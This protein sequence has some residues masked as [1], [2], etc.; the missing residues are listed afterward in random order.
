MKAS[1]VM[2]RPVIS[3]EAGQTVASAIEIMLSR[4]ISGLPVV[5][6]AG[7][8]TGMITEGDFLHRSELGTQRKRPRWL[9]IFTSSGKLAD[10]YTQSRAR[11]VGEI[12]TTDPVTAPEDS[13]LEDIVALMEKHHIKRVPIVRAG[14]PVGIISRS[15]LLHAISTHS[16]ATAAPAQ[17]DSAIRESLSTQLTHE[18]WAP[19]AMINATVRDGIVDLR[20]TILDERER[21]ALIVM[22]ENI[23]GVKTV[24]DH[25][26]WVDPASGMYFSP[27][28]TA[29]SK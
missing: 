28:D 11:K 1:D 21:Q 22:T 9:E 26:V 4:R 16:A 10:E 17:S 24:R 18:K 19:I 12:M 14:K 25:V 27:D 7:R 13:P 29:T 15:D 2:T 23:P 20:G 8:L 3:V 6:E 5:D